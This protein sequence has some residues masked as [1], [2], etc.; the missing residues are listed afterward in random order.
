MNNVNNQN[1]VCL[2]NNNVIMRK[3][4]AEKIDITNTLNAEITT[5][6]DLLKFEASYVKCHIF[7]WIKE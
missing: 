4:T 3:K 6:H 7:I 2:K 1:S 5:K